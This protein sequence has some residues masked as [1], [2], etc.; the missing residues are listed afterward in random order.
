LDNEA[1]ANYFTNLERA[2]TNLTE[3]LTT[4]EE[5]GRRA[6]QSDETINGPIPDWLQEDGGASGRDT[7][8]RSTDPGT[9]KN[10][11]QNVNIV[12][13]AP[14]PSAS[15]TLLS[16]SGQVLDR[17]GREDKY[18]SAEPEPAPTGTVRL[19][20]YQESR[21]QVIDDTLGR[22]EDPQSPAGQA[23]YKTLQ[24]YAGQRNTNLIQQAVDQH[25]AAAVQEATTATAELAAGYRARGMDDAAVLAA[26]QSGEAT[27]AVRENLAAQDLEAP[28]SDEQLGAVADMVLLPQ[29]RFT[30]SELA[31]II[32]R[33]VAAGA[34]SEQ[35]VV[36]AIGSPVG[37]G[38]QTGNIRGV[39]AG[40][41]AMTLLPAEMARLA[42]MIQD[43]LRDAVQ[44]ELAG[45]GYRPEV[46]Q[47]FVSD[48][49]ALPGAVVVPQTTASR[50]PAGS[51][52]ERNQ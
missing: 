15:S 30:R 52:Q 5:I 47:D 38:G 11:V 43:G 17:D 18:E 8:R 39:M 24:V 19:E 14:D 13:A 42:D 27:A 12:S 33:E 20:P 1:L 21:R 2:I 7:V 16:R 51:S 35:A 3:A 50:P 40:A 31:T 25:T 10:E 45:R 48:L 4:G 44:A 6:G 36:D 32:G 26:F 29:R 49:A 9:D 22:L 37:F 28:L 34:E 23:A 46:V 41:R